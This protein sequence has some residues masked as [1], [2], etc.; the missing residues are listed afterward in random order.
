MRSFPFIGGV[1]F[2]F[3]TL[4]AATAEDHWAYQP[5]LE[6]GIPEFATENPIDAF[7]FSRLD[8]SGWMQSPE[9]SPTTLLRRIHLDITG[10]LPSPEE[11]TTFLSAWDNDKEVAWESKVDELLASPHFGE[12]WARHWL[13]IARYGDSDGYLGDTLRHWAWIYRDWVIDSINRD[14]PLDQFAIEQLA[15]DLLKEPSQSQKVATGFHRNNL[16][17]T[18]AGLDKELA[19]TK[20]IVDRTATTGTAWMGL[21]VA[22]AECHDHKH[23]AISQKEFF[24]LYAFFNNTKDSDIAVKLDQEWPPPK[25]EKKKET[26]EPPKP[27]AQAISKLSEEDWR[28]THVHIRGDY[29][30]HGEA[31]SP[32]TPAALPPIRP[33]GGNPDRLDLA[34]WLFSGAN[35]LTPRVVTNQI[36]QQLF[37]V[38]IVATSDDFGTHGTPPSHPQLLDWLALELRKSDWSRKSL[39]RTIV[40][41]STYRQA[42][43]NTYPD[44]PNNLL[45]RQNSFRVNAETVR[46]VHLVASGL[47]T[48]TIGGPSV[49]PPLPEFV[50]KVGRSVK[51]PESTGPNRYRRG[52]YIFLKRT[53]LYPMLTT[54]DA[55]DTSVACSRR[56]ETNTPMQALTLLND[57]V[58]FE[59]AKTLGQDLHRKH[60]DNID[61]AIEE[62]F[63]RCLN[64]K[65][66]PGEAATLVSAHDDFLNEAKSP[67]L[68]MIATARIVMNLDEFITR[69]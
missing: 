44:R 42:S 22:C 7:V 65:P 25:I 60:G 21:T 39:I 69:D 61:A 51:W 8:A 29:T 19:R 26:D 23:D 58:F 33:R 55:P 16:K 6:P 45:W 20:Q 17:N 30:R 40:M 36:W 47:L 66:V 15:G 2:L 56:E 32:N 27:K 64:R 5:I 9:A 57:P 14:Q 53:V 18:E 48:S 3:A 37:G 41:S 63:L 38:G 46:D 13:D 4:L 52:M 11:T 35:P 49:H 24:E 59:C 62:S 10:L 34:T 67:E 1:V 31:V 12:H 43:I 54:F 68:A 50:T 28:E